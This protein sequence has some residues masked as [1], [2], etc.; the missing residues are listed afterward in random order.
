MKN[1]R[2]LT[3]TLAPFLL[4]ALLLAACGP[5]R[6]SP[7]PTATD[8][9]ML[10]PAKLCAPPGT[11]AEEITSSGQLRKYW[12]HV[13]P[14]YQPAQATALVLGF[15]GNGGYADGF[16]GYSGFSIVA[17]REGFLTVYP[18]GLGDTPGWN[19]GPGDG[20]EDIRFVRD[21]LD[22]L[23]TRCNI[24][25]ARVYAIGHSRGGGMANRL[26][27]NLADRIAAIGP[28]SGAYQDGEYCD[29]SRPVPIFAIHGDHDSIIPYNG[30]PT[31]GSPGAY[32][33]I[34][35]PIPQWAAAW[36]R[37]NGC[38]PK[39]TILNDDE[40]VSEQGWENCTNGADVVL[41][42]VKGGE[43]SWPPESFD[44][45]QLIWDFLAKHP[46]KK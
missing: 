13:P 37:R 42:T 3:V 45:A 15:H 9:A 39:P 8:P 4:G 38:N 14:G 5:V 21:L 40:Q 44:A 24:D 43:H 30:F 26:A 16:E 29:P 12:L 10:T 22:S 23:E 11:H 33:T 25:P 20:N 19:T 41:Y 7:L 6:A 28:V 31:T 35:V 2:I 46:L 36:A 34:G 18:Q 17:D 1:R 32:F 27:C